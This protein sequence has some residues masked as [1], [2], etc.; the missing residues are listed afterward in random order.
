MQTLRFLRPYKETH[1]QY[2][3]K[4]SPFGEFLF[5]QGCFQQNAEI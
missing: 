1:S 4:N 2:K 3:R 5:V